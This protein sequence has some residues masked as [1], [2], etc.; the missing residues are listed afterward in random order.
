MKTTDFSKYLHRF[1]VH[2]LAE[3]RNYSSNTIDTY[4]YTFILF[5][6]YLEK[7]EIKSDRFEIKDLT[8]ELISDFLNNLQQTRQ[9]TVA[10]YN[11]RLAAILSFVR[12]LSYEY[13]D[14]LNNYNAILSIPFKKSKTQTISH[15]DIEGIKLLIKQVDKST[16]K[17]YRNFMVIFILYET[18]TRVSELINIR[19]KDFHRQKPYYLKVNGKGNKERVI[20]VAKEVVDELN[21]YLKIT[22][23]DEKPQDYLLFANSQ[24]EP[25]SRISINN[26]L[27]KYSDKAREIDENLIPKKIT[28]H[29]LR[30]SKAMHL[31]QSGVNIVYIR[32][33]LGHS[34]IQTTEIYARANSKAK[35]EAIESSYTDIYPKETPKWQDKSILEWLKRFY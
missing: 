20:P 2:Y 29:V 12:F 19:I 10:T 31:L 32:D 14:Y 28:P 1:L 15:L 4:R 11:N 5:L 6:E 33:F 25:L 9:I 16:P 17:G 24:G 35:Q 7:N 13:P 26:I 22:A 30:H 8:Y 23:L 3:V 21:N 18:G 27:K 34:S